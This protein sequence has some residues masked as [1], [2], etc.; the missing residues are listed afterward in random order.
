MADSFMLSLKIGATAAGALS[1]LGDTQRAIG[2]LGAGIERHLG[3]LAPKTIAA[4][5]R[6]YD[7]LGRSIERLQSKQIQLTKLAGLSDSL[8]EPP[9]CKLEGR[10]QEGGASSA[11]LE[12]P[13]QHSPASMQGCGHSDGNAHQ[14]RPNQ[15][16]SHHKK[17]P[18]QHDPNA[19]HRP[20]PSERPHHKDK[21][22]ELK[23]QSGRIAYVPVGEKSTQQRRV[24]GFH[25]AVSSSLPKDKSA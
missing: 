5:A 23:Q 20:S 21:A 9:P 25:G 15:C 13:A 8:R 14:R 10:A 24:V 3:T 16:K 11:G 22:T 2:R 17:R 6:D 12:H 7:S 4:L 18:S 19:R 1:A